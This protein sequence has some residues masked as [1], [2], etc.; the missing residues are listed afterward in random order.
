M[1]WLTHNVSA[2]LSALGGTWEQ[3]FARLETFHRLYGHC[4]VPSNPAFL[5]ATHC[6]RLR[7]ESND[8]DDGDEVR[9]GGRMDSGEYIQD[10][11]DYELER[12][13][14]LR[15]L[16]RWCRQ[17]RRN[18]FAL[19]P[20]A[21]LHAERHARLDR[22]GFV[23]DP[24]E[25]RWAAMFAKLKAFRARFGHTNVPYDFTDLPPPPSGDKAVE[26]EKGQD[27]RLGERGWGVES[28]AVGATTTTTPIQS[29]PLSLRPGEGLG[30]WVSRMRLANRTASSK[31]L[32]RERRARLE[33]IGFRRE[34]QN[35]VRWEL[36]L[37]RLRIFRD[38]F[39]HCNAPYTPKSARKLL[40]HHQ[41]SSPEGGG[42]TARV[43]SGA[44][45]S[46]DTGSGGG[47]DGDTSATASGAD[48]SDDLT[49]LVEIGRWVK[50]Q[51]AAF[52]NR[53]ALLGPM[54]TKN[55]GVLTDEKLQL[56]REAGLE[57]EQPRMRSQSGQGRQHQN[58]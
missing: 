8:A 38:R 41:E 53:R 2:A 3:Q 44:A 48:A 30:K 17:Q 37:R 50:Y 7:E 16:Q 56:L 19:G 54:Q 47:A 24:Q 58:S 9:S 46:G 32:N 57:L 10:N 22:I 12:E 34:L 27:A 25:R 31:V 52:R 39:G 14:A 36:M 15:D 35:D 26:K 1:K 40:V 18:Q 43:A 55:V 20:G 42:I 11:V 23:W 5:V 21:K 51:R 28:R 4:E 29:M 45:S 13:A 33:G 6:Q 49:S